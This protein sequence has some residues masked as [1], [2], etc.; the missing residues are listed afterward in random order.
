[1]DPKPCT[2]RTSN[3]DIDKMYGSIPR[4]QRS[5]VM[6]ESAEVHWDIT[7]LSSFSSSGSSTTSSSLEGWMGYN[8]HSSVNLELGK[9]ECY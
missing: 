5:G 9:F 6:A 3:H 7:T 1:M 4:P 8:F 2:V